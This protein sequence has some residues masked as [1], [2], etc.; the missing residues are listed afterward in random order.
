MLYADQPCFS[1]YVSW[2]GMDPLSGT[3]GPTFC[4]VASMKLMGT[5]D[6][7]DGRRREGLLGW[8]VNRQGI[9]FQGRPNKADDCCC[10]FWVGATL[11][12][13]DGLH[14]VDEARARQFHVSC[15]DKVLG[16]FAKAPG[17]PPDLLHSFYSLCWLSLSKEEGLEPMD[18]AL[19][20]TRRASNRVTSGVDVGS[21]VG[22]FL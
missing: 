21:A 6:S 2:R 1:M 3:A 22:V 20:I 15:Q 19:G 11:A 16:G 5:L 7:I 13:L 9:G 10:S 4:A 17:E 12:L 14:L 8:C 18:A